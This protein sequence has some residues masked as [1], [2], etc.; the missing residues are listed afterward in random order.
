VLGVT[1]VVG[2]LP[3]ASAAV[4]SIATAAAA[5]PVVFSGALTTV[6]VPVRIDPTGTQ[7][8][9]PALTDFFR[10]IGNGSRVLLAPGATYRIETAVVIKDKQD[11]LIDGNGAKTITTTRGDRTRQHWRVLGGDRIAIRNLTVKGANPNAGTS[12]G[13]GVT[14][15][16][17]QHGFNFAGTHGVDLYN[18]TVTDVY[19]DFVYLGW[20]SG[21]GRWSEDVRVHDSTFL[22]NGRQ[23]M[24]LTGARRVRIDNNVIGQTRRAT[25]DLEPNGGRTGVEDVTIENND[26]GPGRLNFISAVGSGPVNRVV[27]RNNTLTG[28]AMNS[29]LGSLTERRSD[30]TISG[31][32]SDTR[33]GNPSGGI[34]AFRLIDRIVVSRNTQPAQVGRAMHLVDLNASCAA[35]VAGNRV[36]AGAEV[37]TSAPCPTV[38]G[39]DRPSRSVVKSLRLKSLRPIG[40]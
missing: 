33:F 35:V 37:R 26:V 4:P 22:R 12:E 36:S 11:L 3:M 24:A 23:G 38:A 13:A 8:V 28:R 17:A 19:G 25:F 7:D 5:R 21:T 18:V 16:E 2:T 40:R 10:S 1:N 6:P 31:N 15:L 27:V 9:G 29:T 39:Q 32:T 14:E 20:D 34:M 30:W